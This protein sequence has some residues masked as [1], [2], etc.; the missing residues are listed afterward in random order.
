[1][2]HTCYICGK[3][4]C[5]RHHIFGGANR[6]KSEKYGLVVRLCRECHN[7]GHFGKRSKE[8]MKMLREDGRRKFE[9]EHPNLDFKDTFHANYLDKKEPPRQSIDIVPVDELAKELK[10]GK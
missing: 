7:Q 1:M 8:L 6:P 2:T 3:P 4:A 5:E 10:G 9:S